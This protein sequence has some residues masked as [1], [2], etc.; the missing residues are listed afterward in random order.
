MPLLLSFGFFFAFLF[1][2]LSSFFHFGQ[3][4][5]GIMERRRYIILYKIEMV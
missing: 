3:L 4:T 2:F 5:K 1:L